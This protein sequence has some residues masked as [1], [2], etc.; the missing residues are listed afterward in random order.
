MADPLQRDANRVPVMGAVSSLSSTTVSPITYTPITGVNPVNVAIV[1]AS[2][3]QITSFGGGTQYA[4]AAVVAT[5]TGTVA[6]GYDGANVRA[7]LT[8]TTGKL[9]V[10][11]SITA[12]NPSVGSTGVAIPTSATLLGGSD[13]TNLQ[14]LQIDASKNLKV[15]LAN[16]SVA[17]TGTFWQATQPVSGTFWQT[18]QPVS[19]ASLPP[20]ATGTNNIGVVDIADTAGNKFTSNSTTF[21]SKYAQDINLLGTLGTAF[22]TAGKI[23][24][25]AIPAGTNLIGKVEVSDGTNILNTTTNPAVV[26]EIPTSNTGWSFNYQSALSNTKA[27]IKGTAGIFGGYVMLYNPNTAVTYIQVFNKA[28]ANVTVGTTA[29]DF[30]IPLPG[31]ASASATGSAANVEFSVGIVMNTGITVA[32]TT[33]PTGSTAPANAIMATFLYL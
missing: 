30:V 29:P 11:G 1:D 23:D 24:I 8:D 3:T 31:V 20:L 5:P 4:N 32:A 16:A 33:T 10:T 6:L 26:S 25:T 13:G 12:T 22:S 21:T 7:L 19:L 9:N 14:P 18:T 2:G 17:V 15:L 28:S 27:Q